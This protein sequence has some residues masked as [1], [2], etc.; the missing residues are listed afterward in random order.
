MPIQQT[1]H[2]LIMPLKHLGG[3]GRPSL[4]EAPPGVNQHDPYLASLTI[5]NGGPA[6]GYMP[7]V[8]H[9]TG[10]LLEE[11]PTED[12][13]DGISQFDSF[14]VDLSGESKI[15]IAY[16]VYYN[17]YIGGTDRGMLSYTTNVNA[18]KAFFHEPEY[19]GGGT[20][21]IISITDPTNQFYARSFAQPSA[22]VY[23]H[24]VFVLDRTGPSIT[25]YVDAS[26]VTLGVVL[27]SPITGNYANDLVYLGRVNT[28]L[29]GAG[30]VKHLGIWS[31]I[32]TLS[33][34]DI[35]ALAGIGVSGDVSVSTILRQ[36]GREID[37][38]SGPEVISLLRVPTRILSVSR[39]SSSSLLRGPSRLLT[40]VV[41]SIARLIRNPFRS[42]TSTGIDATSLLRQPNKVLSSSGGDSSLLTRTP[43]IVLT[44]ST[45]SSSS[46]V[47]SPLRLI[48]SIGNSINSLI[49]KP[50]RTI[51]S[52]GID[53]TT[54]IKQPGHV[55]TSSAGDTSSI[56]RTALRLLS[57]SAT[58]VSVIIR[59]PSRILSYVVTSISSIVRNPQRTL[60]VSG[61]SSTTLVRSVGRSLSANSVTVS[62]LAFAVSFVLSVVVTTVATVAAV[63]VTGGI[64]LTC[65][66]AS[67]AKLIKQPNKTL[68]TTDS[69]STVLARTPNRTLTSIGVSS[70]ILTRT[71]S[72]ILTSIADPVAALRKTAGRVLTVSETSI[73]VVLPVRV[74]RATL[75]SIGGDTSS[76]QRTPLRILVSQGHPISTIKRLAAHTL[77]YLS[78]SNTFLRKSGSTTLVI[79]NIPEGQS[80]ISLAVQRTLIASGNSL[81]SFVSQV[82][83]FIAHL[84]AISR[85]YKQWQF[86]GYQVYEVNLARQ[87]FDIVASK[88]YSI[89]RVFK[90]WQ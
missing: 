79:E 39:P 6:D 66:G 36:Q 3:F 16:W 14:A 52:T 76:L 65:A 53:T 13:Y 59:A 50:L 22:G 45:V 29:Y 89:G 73:P 5:T 87:R 10:L 47:R 42:I 67:V 88:V 69:S 54:L 30:K 49:R 38:T 80:S 34:G 17:A 15:T 84:F 82:F 8:V 62:S 61:T 72:R 63:V 35:N 90:R 43:S 57:T 21:S 32:E 1:N 44:E 11:L 81:A 83:P 74:K 70:A 9:P 60:T 78:V 2:P 68:S 40:T 33:Q 25:V 28:T 64:V 48:S 77:R 55:L 85:V 56:L 51:T 31:G 46:L 18:G 7:S 19:S 23:H 4:Q 86:D 41:T 24:F 20:N 75:A 37:A 12:S 58:S 71:A 27:S 26:P